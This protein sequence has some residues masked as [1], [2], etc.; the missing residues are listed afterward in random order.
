MPNHF[1]L[2]WSWPNVLKTFWSKCKSLFFISKVGCLI[3]F[4][5]KQIFK[6]V[7][8]SWIYDIFML[9]II[10]MFLSF[11]KH[12]SS[13]NNLVNNSWNDLF[14]KVESSHFAELIWILLSSMNMFI[15]VYA[16]FPLLIIQA[17]NHLL[18]H[19]FPQFLG[20]WCVLFIE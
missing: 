11:F 20:V 4:D 13:T 6:S 10:K 14:F 1:I 7:A 3:P 15:M 9:R 17:R 16:L 5:P 8:T 12:F 19:Y 18:L 2:H